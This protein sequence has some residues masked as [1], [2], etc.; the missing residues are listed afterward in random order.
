MRLVAF[1]NSVIWSTCSAEVLLK[2]T[3]FVFQPV[4][5]DERI[6]IRLTD[7]TMHS[8]YIRTLVF[9]NFANFFSSASGERKSGVLED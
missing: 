6:F 2:Q 9:A 8:R 4:D 3:V 7:K 5:E 1:C